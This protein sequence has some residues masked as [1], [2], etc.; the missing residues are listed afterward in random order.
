[1]RTCSRDYARLRTSHTWLDGNYSKTAQ[2]AWRGVDG[3]NVAALEWLECSQ[4][5]YT[6]LDDL[7]LWDDVI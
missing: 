7:M 5:V 6:D 1:M 3:S 2:I 4:I